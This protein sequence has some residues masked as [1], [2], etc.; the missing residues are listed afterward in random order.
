MIVLCEPPRLAG[1]VS[2]GFRYQ[3]E[4]MA[5]RLA[6]HDGERR[7]VAPEQLAA[8]V[9]E[10][11]RRTGTVVV[12]DGLFAQH[13]PLPVGVVALL[14]MVPSR[15][16]WSAVPCP[17]LA[18]AAGTVEAPRVRALAN[19]TEVVE[20]GLDPCFRPAEHPPRAS[21]GSVRIVCIGTFGPGKGQAALWQAVASAAVPCEL[22]LLGAG[23]EQFAPATRSLG[24]ATVRGRGVVAPADVAAELQAAD[25]C[26]SWSRSESFG[27]AVAEAVACGTP[28]LAFS[29][30]AIPTLVQ[31]GRNGWLLPAD[32]DDAAMTQQLHTLLGDRE[33]LRAAR[34]SAVRPNLAPWSVVAE[35][36]AAACARLAAHVGNARHGSPG[37]RRS[38]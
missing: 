32:A 7:V 18:T 2:G 20:P 6:A 33:L 14:H 35:R 29:T 23:T 4:V 24:L 13:A 27:M 11:R 22:V 17:V 10:L 26:V 1:F 25:L 16:A 8:T 15:D 12:V 31:S 19:A 38:R 34:A 21:E 5:P 28:V 3:D 9:A 37:E 30:G 36:F